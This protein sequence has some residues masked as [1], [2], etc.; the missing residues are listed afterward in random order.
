[1]TA[2]VW[3]IKASLLDYVRGRGAGSVEAADGATAE[4]DA[5][6]FPA[7]SRTTGTD[8]AFLG[9]VTLTAH[10]GMLR[11]VIAEPAIVQSPGGWTLEVADPHEPGARLAF[12]TIAAFDGERASGTALTQDGADLFFGPYEPGT[13][14]DD[15]RVER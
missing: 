7:G 14:I 13:P 3:G 2:L 15:P 11:L 12:A 4:H 10:G 6:R 1:M 5:F 8:G 9:S